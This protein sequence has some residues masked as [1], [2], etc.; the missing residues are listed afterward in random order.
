MNQIT[1]GR[2]VHYRSLGSADGAYPSLCRAAI[3]TDCDDPELPP[4]DHTVSVAVFNP[5]GMFFNSTQYDSHLAPG[6]WHWYTDC[7]DE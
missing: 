1:I 5:G 7:Q 3:I 6:T 4:H 2:V